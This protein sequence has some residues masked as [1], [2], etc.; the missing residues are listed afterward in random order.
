M[1][2][3]RKAL[4]RPRKIKEFGQCGFVWFDIFSVPPTTLRSR[5]WPLHPSPY[6]ADAGMFIVLAPG[7]VKHDWA[8]LDLSTWASRGGVARETSNAL[9][10]R[11]LPNTVLLATAPNRLES[12]GPAAAERMVR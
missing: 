5:A 3:G 8:A 10:C 4:S 12:H 1:T 6:V 7:G 11:P 9:T 2:W